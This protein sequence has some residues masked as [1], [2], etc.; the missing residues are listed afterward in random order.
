MAYDG[1]GNFLR[2]FNWVQDAA[3]NIDI[4]AS[5]V[6]AEDNGIAAGL[7]LAV[8]RD[9]QGKMTSDFLPGVDGT[10]N[11]GSGAFRW[12]SFNVKTATLGPPGGG[13][14]AITVNGVSAQYAAIVNGNVTASNSLGLAVRAGTNSADIALQVNNQANSLNYLIVAGDGGVYLGAP[15]GATQGKGTLNVDTGLLINGTNVYPGSPINTQNAN[16]TVVPADTG[17]T[18]YKSGGAAHTDTFPAGGTAVP[19]GFTCDFIVL[20]GANPLTISCADNAGG[21]FFSPS[22]GNT[23]TR[24]LAADGWARVTKTAVGTYYISGFGIT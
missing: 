19:V 2:L 15:T 1:N 6:D 11:L 5:R 7:S 8:T 12:A 22:G 21:F 20:H 3:N 13:L 9:G 4:T 24:T 23:A 14:A 17:K 10:L 18:I 16:Y